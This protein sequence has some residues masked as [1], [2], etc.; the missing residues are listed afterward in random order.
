MRFIGFLLLAMFI[1]A[2]IWYGVNVYQQGPYW[3]S[4]AYNSRVTESTVDRGDISD[5]NGYTLAATQDGKRVYLS[6]ETA[7][8]ALSQTIGDT[9]GMS[10]TGVETFFASTLLDTSSS[11]G[12]QVQELLNGQRRK[13]ANIQL[14]IDARLQAYAASI[15]P[16]E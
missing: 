9:K 16:E 2:G 8:R 14:T 1:G 3:A 7:R 4:T 15:F 5:R 11:L 13:G 6:N 10:G 12:T